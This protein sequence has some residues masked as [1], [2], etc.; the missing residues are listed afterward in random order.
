M[1]EGK[2]ALI[3]QRLTRGFRRARHLRKTRGG[4]EID[5]HTAVLGAIAR[6]GPRPTT[7]L[8][9]IRIS[10]QE[11]FHENVTAPK[12]AEVVRCLA[13]MSKIANQMEGE[14]P[15]EWVSGA[16][17]LEII[18]PFFLFSLKWSHI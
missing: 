3:Y 2:S 15:L 5:I 7:T 11:V 14:P 13:S 12:R 8:E 4:G 16:Q 1:A 10:L 17:R 18:D 6:L 9:E